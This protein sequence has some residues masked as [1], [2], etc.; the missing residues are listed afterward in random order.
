MNAAP[1]EEVFKTSPKF[2]SCI[3]F[4]GLKAVGGTLI[5]LLQLMSSY[6]ETIITSVLLNRECPKAPSVLQ[7]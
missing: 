1:L 6:F 5:N 2:S 4:A 7:Q 3:H